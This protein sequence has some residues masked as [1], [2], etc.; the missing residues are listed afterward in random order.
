MTNEDHFILAQR[1]NA[2]AESELI[3]HLLPSLKALT[4]KFETQYFG[5]QIEADDLLQEE[6]ISLLRAVYS[7]R[8][9]KG[10]LFQT[11]A[12][13]VSKNMMM[14]Y[15]RKCASAILDRLLH[16]S[17]I[18]NIVGPSYWTKDVLEKLEES[19]RKEYQ[20]T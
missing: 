14:D 8:P 19:K 12:S 5:L 20:A 4:A 13:L 16:H 9:E 15:V 2:D 10:Y 1:G 17:H 3:D 6:S 11:F 7:F 18:V